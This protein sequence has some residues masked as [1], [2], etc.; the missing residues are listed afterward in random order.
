[1]KER[2]RLMWLSDGGSLLLQILAEPCSEKGLI[3]LS[4]YLIAILLS[5][6]VIHSSKIGILAKITAIMVGKVD[7]WKK[8]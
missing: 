2:E 8:L 6:F 4:C 3:L 5:Y 1:M 7:L